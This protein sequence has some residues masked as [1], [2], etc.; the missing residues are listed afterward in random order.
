MIGIFTLKFYF[1]YNK[2]LNLRVHCVCRWQQVTLSLWALI[3]CLIQQRNPKRIDNAKLPILKCFQNWIFLLHFLWGET[4]MSSGP[5]WGMK[6]GNVSWLAFLMLVFLTIQGSVCVCVCVCLCVSVSVSVCVCV[7][8]CLCVCVDDQASWG[9]MLWGYTIA[10]ITAHGA[11]QSGQ[12]MWPSLG[13]WP[14]SK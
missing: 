10:I 12:H 5:S 13:P 6:N 8:L 7:C 4:W 11:G 1:Q 3:V 9:K 14:Y 2:F